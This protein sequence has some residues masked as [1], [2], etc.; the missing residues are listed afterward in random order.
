MSCA[1]T[2]PNALPVSPVS[3]VNSIRALPIASCERK[4]TLSGWIQPREQRLMNCKLPAP[5]AVGRAGK[6]KTPYPVCCFVD[7]AESFVMVRFQSVKPMAQRE[8]VMFAQILHITDFE[9]SRL[10]SAQ[11]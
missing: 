5:K 10:R 8:R 1:V 11:H 9:V 6:I 3:S 7:E 2:E 4:V